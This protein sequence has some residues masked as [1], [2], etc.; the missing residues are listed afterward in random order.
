[1]E[2]F[3]SWKACDIVQHS[4]NQGIAAAIQTGLKNAR[5]EIVCSIDADCTYDPLELMNML[6]LL[7]DGVDLVTASPY[8]P[9]GAVKNVPAWRLTLSKGA[10]FLYRQVLRS[11]LHTFTSCCRVYRRSAVSDLN[12]RHPGFQGVAELLAQVIRRGG[13][14]VEHPAVLDV[15]RYGQSKMRVLSTIGGHLELLA[16]LLLSRLTS[17]TTA[18]GT[19]AGSALS[20]PRSGPLTSPHLERTTA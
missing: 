19:A 15:R 14:V 17:S 12:V 2:T 10:A 11:P 7:T 3:S 5:T 8:H 4:R 16:Q 20:P 18:A 6:P 9:A 13:R 1:M